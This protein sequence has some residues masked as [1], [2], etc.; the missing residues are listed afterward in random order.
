MI[1]GFGQPLA[2]FAYGGMGTGNP[3]AQIGQSSF[4]G[5]GGL[6]G[7]PAAGAI[8]SDFN[9]AQHQ[10][11]PMPITQPQPQ[12]QPWFHSVIPQDQ[13]QPQPYTGPYVAATVSP[14]MNQP[15]VIDPSLTQEKQASDFTPM[16]GIE[17]RPGLRSDPLDTIPEEPI[18]EQL[19]TPPV[20]TGPRWEDGFLVGNPFGQGDVANLRDPITGLAIAES[21]V[22]IGDDSSQTV[23]EGEI[24]D[25]GGLSQLLQNVGLQNV[26]EGRYRPIARERS[27][28]LSLP[29]QQRLTNLL[30]DF[31]RDPTRT[32]ESLNQ[33][34]YGM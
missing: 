3:Y 20:P 17:P 16:P 5:F 18:V 7:L 22:K 14:I 11:Y 12:P 29:D 30:Y 21:D 23:A 9:V 2:Q 10:P 27:R 4:S 34:L 33:Q 15:G 24:S 13:P 26:G 28:Q 31:E 8:G 6:S 25:A 19:Q 1:Q 32:L